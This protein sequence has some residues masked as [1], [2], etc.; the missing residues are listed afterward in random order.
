MADWKIEITDGP[1]KTSAVMATRD[2]GEDNAP[3]VVRILSIAKKEDE[4][5][6]KFIARIASEVERIHAK[7]VSQLPKR[8]LANAV[9]AKMKKG[10]KKQ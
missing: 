8:T 9:E 4:T 10:G 6:S 2:N 5:D 3:D 7:N 1:G